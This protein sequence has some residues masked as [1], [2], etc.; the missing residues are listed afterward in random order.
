MRAAALTLVPCLLLATA[1]SLAQVSVE[2]IAAVGDAIGATSIER[3]SYAATDSDSDVIYVVRQQDLEQ[4][5]FVNGLQVFD[6][7]TAPITLDYDP[8]LTIDSLGVSSPTGWMYLPATAGK[9]TVYTDQGQ[10]ITEGAAAPGYPVAA[11]FTNIERATRVATNAI[12]FHASVDV[13]GDLLSDE[14]ALYRTL[15]GTVGNLQPLLRNGSTVD[16]FNVT[17][18]ARDYSVSTDG[19]HYVST[20]V[21]AGSARA[22]VVDGQIGALKGAATG[23]EGNWSSFGYVAVS[24]SGAWVAL[25][26]TDAPTLRDQVVMYN[27]QVALR[28][29]DVTG[30]VPLQNP[31]QAR[32]VAINDLDQVA[33]LWTYASGEESLFFSCQGDSLASTSRLILSEDDEVDVD[34]DGVADA[35]LKEFRRPS[36]RRNPIVLTNDRRL[37]FKADL[38]FLSG[39]KRALISVAVTCCGDGTVDA[40][41]ECDGSGETAT[42]DADCTA[43][44]C[45]DRTVNLALGE[46]C[47]DGGESGTCN[48]D[49]TLAMCGDGVENAAAGEACDG[50]GES[51]TCNADCTAAVCGDGQV[52]TTAGESCDDGGRE[53]ATCDSDC[54]IPACG[55][56]VH[57]ATA[58]EVCD[59]GGATATCDI[60]CSVPE[61]GDGILNLA[62]GES[63]EDGNA[64]DG[65]GCSSA[66][67]LEGGGAGGSDSG[68][69]GGTGGL[70]GAG[71][72][73]GSAGVGG[74]GAAGGLAGS[75]GSGGSGAGAG[76][77]EGGAGPA[78]GDDSGG[79]GC[80]VASSGGRWS[81]G[82]WTAWFAA[83]R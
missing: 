81:L 61:C 21:G 45:G 36:N 77:S 62:A 63:C 38:G 4:R 60:D 50:A 8:S 37:I 74:V 79:C 47:D 66:C 43:A 1:P 35:T 57:N 46:A 64:T 71:G 76:A 40:G 51:A 82:G 56:G 29:G 41:E 12:Y 20:V 59:E 22:L 23:D 48:A 16:A 9:L 73:G 70:A 26:D 17:A 33:H 69:G 49:C 83:S 58:G 25:A 15:D 78:A 31:A 3:I 52:N 42:C 13:T 72:S 39:T 6:S 32:V 80:R 11:T 19:S 44:M 34:G 53:T 27:G 5:V 24:N 55:D 75:G 68:G 18:I 7:T 30:G 65:D 67:Q 2:V 54:T 14:S 10:L 28:E